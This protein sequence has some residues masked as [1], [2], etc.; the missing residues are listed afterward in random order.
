MIIEEPD[1]RLTL[2]ASGLSW[3]LELLRTIKSRDGSAKEEFRLE[4]YGIPIDRC[5][6]IISNYRLEKKQE[7]YTLKKYISD[8]KQQI[9]QLKE[10]LQ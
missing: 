4:G 9:K 5:L 8:Y 6:Q 1:F 3:D 7:V 10:I 2:S